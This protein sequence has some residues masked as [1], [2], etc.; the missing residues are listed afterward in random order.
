MKLDDVTWSIGYLGLVAIFFM[1]NRINARRYDVLS[2][3]VSDLYD[4][5]I[6][7]KLRQFEPEDKQ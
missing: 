1:E 6:K 3:A 5:V 2:K 7:I 4:H